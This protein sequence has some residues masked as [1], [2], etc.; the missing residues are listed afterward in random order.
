[1]VGLLDFLSGG[2]QGG[3]LG[4]RFDPSQFDQMQPAGIP[5]WLKQAMFGAQQGRRVRPR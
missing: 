5:D 3:L 4:G 1:M 2:N